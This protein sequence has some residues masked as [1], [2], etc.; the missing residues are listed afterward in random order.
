M[1]SILH[2]TWVSLEVAFALVWGCFFVVLGGLLCASIVFIWLGV[3]CLFISGIP[4]ASIVRREVERSFERRWEEKHRD[5]PMEND[6]E[7]P[8]II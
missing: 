3:P 5:K 4:L 7:K 6:A 1:R 8:W 2:W